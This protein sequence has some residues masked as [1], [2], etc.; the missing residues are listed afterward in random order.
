MWEGRERG[1]TIGIEAR[2][3][4][5]LVGSFHTTLA[6]GTGV[7][8]FQPPIRWRCGTWGLPLLGTQAEP[9]KRGLRAGGAAG[10]LTSA[11]P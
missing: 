4:F 10:G 9:H 2:L 3:H 7:E 5:P 6:G 8:A 1:D 11:A